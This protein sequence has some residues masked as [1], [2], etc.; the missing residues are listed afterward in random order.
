MNDAH[1]FDLIVIGGGSA[2]LAGAFRAA[3]HGARV[4]MFEPDALGGTCVNVGCVP[5]KAMWLAADLAERGALAEAFGFGKATLPADWGKLLA[6]RAAYIERI[7]GIYRERLAKAGIVLV[8]QY[9]RLLDAHTVQAADGDRFSA[10]HVLLATGGH[11]LRPD[12]PGADA[13][14]VSDDFFALDHAPGRVALVGGGYVA[15]ELS[16]V[17][18]ALGSHVETFV[19]GD[20]LLSGFDAELAAQLRD[21][22]ARQ[23]IVEHF[24]HRLVAIRADGAQRWLRDADGK[25]SGPFDA[26]FLATGRAPNTGGF[27]LD[28]VGVALDAKGHVIVDAWQDTSVPGIHAVGDVT[29]RPALTPVAIAAARRLMDRVFGGRAEARLDYADIPS[30]VFSHPPLGKVGLTETEARALH[31]DGVQVFR[32][33]FVPMLESLAGSGRRSLF[34]VVC[35]GGERRVLGIHLLGDGADEILQGFAVALK[36]GIT[37][38]DLQDTVPIHPTSAE[39]VVLVGG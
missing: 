29:A 11:P 18:H 6:R 8:P 25:E 36:R 32:A 19:R 37:L 17:L 10:P 33:G 27:G 7:H 20:A 35:A 1:T 23:G 28:A 13:A 12:I 24:G 34:K 5:K 15:V 3:G 30:V 22:R 2:G 21:E 9:A 38:Q 26:V 16:G 14:W 4:A 39:E 31:G